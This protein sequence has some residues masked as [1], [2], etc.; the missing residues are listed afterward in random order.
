MWACSRVG[1]LIPL[2]FTLFF[3]LSSTYLLFIFSLYTNGGFEFLG[4]PYAIP[5]VPQKNSINKKLEVDYT[6]E[7][8]TPPFRLEHCWKD[9]LKY[10]RSKPQDCLQ[11]RH[12]AKGKFETVGSQDCLTLDIYSPIVGYD[13]PSP[14]VVVIATPTL[15]GGWSDKAHQGRNI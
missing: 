6:W 7:P 3:A 9:V 13:T 12:T 11:L 8:G 14:V 4:I 10:P 15:F 2:Y 1:L 5:P